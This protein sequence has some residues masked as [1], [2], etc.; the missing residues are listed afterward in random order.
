L[1]GFF[2][3]VN[4]LMQHALIIDWFDSVWIYILI[5]A[6]FGQ[7]RQKQLFWFHVQKFVG[8]IMYESRAEAIEQAI[9][10]AN[11]IYNESRN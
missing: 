4:P 1:S 7:K 8:T 2:D 5:K 11:T 3:T 10:K 9:I 6:K